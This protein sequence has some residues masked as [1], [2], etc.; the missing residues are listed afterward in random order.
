MYYLPIS[1]LLKKPR[2]FRFDRNED[3]IRYR[4]DSFGIAGFI[5]RY[6]YTST[7]RLTCSMDYRMP[8]SPRIDEEKDDQEHGLAPLERLHHFLAMLE[9]GDPSQRWKA[10]ESL[11]RLRDDRAVAPLILA[12]RDDDW[13]VR[14]KAA[15]ALG[16]IGDPRALVPLRRALMHE[17]EGVKEIIMESL[18]E[19]KG[20]RPL[21]KE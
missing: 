3:G 10:A 5:N 15:W 4:S 16:K 8:A 7:H 12:L 18:D 13:R 9:E 6:T 11:G 17:T 1:P 19:I 20:T 21:E 2:L 14:Q